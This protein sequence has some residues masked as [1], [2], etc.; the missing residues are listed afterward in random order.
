MEEEGF[1][2]TTG[3]TGIFVGGVI[4]VGGGLA[5]LISRMA[6]RHVE[7]AIQQNEAY[8]TRLAQQP[9]AGGKRRT[10][11]SSHPRRDTRRV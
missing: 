7:D 9:T 2:S 6:T 1:I 8:R 4:V 3:W 11:R 10:R 5:F